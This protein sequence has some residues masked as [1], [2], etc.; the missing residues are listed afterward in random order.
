[1]IVKPKIDTKSLG[2]PRSN[3]RWDE[4]TK[5]EREKGFK[6]SS[7]LIRFRRNRKR[8][9]TKCFPTED[10]FSLDKYLKSLK[11]LKSHIHPRPD[12]Y[13]IINSM[14]IPLD[15]NDAFPNK[16]RATIFSLITNPTI[17]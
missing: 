7:Y 8:Y 2:I 4:K 14:A 15:P 12:Y 1:M 5:K 13:N 6:G 10:I 11:Y 9:A 16:R 17:F 3:D